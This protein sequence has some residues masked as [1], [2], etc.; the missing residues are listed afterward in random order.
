MAQTKFDKQVEENAESLMFG[1]GRVLAGRDLDGVKRTDATFWRP[2]TRVLPKVEGRVPRRSYRAGWQRLSFR[3]VL[4]AGVV[5]S[6]YLLSRDPEATARTFQDLW[7]NRDVTLA[8]LETGGIG[9][10]SAMAV[11]GVAYGLLTRERRELMR[12]WV[13]PLH[14]ALTIPLGIAEQTAP[15]RYLH[16][17]KNFTDD[18]AQIRVD[19]PTHLRFSRDVVADLITQKLAL[20]GVTFSWHPAGRKPYVLVKKTRKPPVKAA[21]KDP[22]VRELVARAKE[23]APVIGIGSS[24]RIVSVDLD[25]DSPHILVNAST[26]GGKSVT[27]RCIACQMLHHGSLVF[28]LDFKR[29]SHP[30]ARGIPGVT[31][32]ADIA[33]IHDQLIELGM[34][35]RRRTRVADELGIDADPHAI[36]PRLLI[37]LEE[38]NATMKQLARYWERIRES[39]DPKVSPAVDALNEVL[40]MGRQLRMHV[41]L[42]AQSATARALGG[43]EVREQFA[44]RILARYSVN[45]WRMLAP[46]VHPAPKS[47]KHHGRAQVVIGGTARETQVLFFTEAEAREWATTGKAA[48]DPKRAAL[49]TQLQ[50]PPAP[51]AQPATSAD[52]LTD[53]WSTAPAAPEPT[54]AADRDFLADAWSIEPQAP[55]TD[56][57]GGAADT[58]TA[59]SPANSAVVDDDQ[60]VGLRQ[61]HEHHLPEITLAALRFARANDP[62]FPDPAGKRGAELL[63]RVGDLKRWAR[64]RP[65]AASG[66]TDLG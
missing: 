5:E 43:P 27:L 34:E 33:D 56:P 29:I 53:A 16:I 17:P 28:V 10:A 44:T 45:A 20:E 55:A 40:Y 8:T 21:F 31:Y 18:D 15:R 62:S 23:S 35:G 9:A 7:G 11:G 66:T 51:D 54:Q 1:I 13:V 30:W 50:K 48:P 37:L 63:Y 38:I 2:A 26:G 65:R 24:N 46:E 52:L 64:N 58:T 60:A 36:G 6:G 22:M 61:A 47:T 57:G 59:M 3:L 14:E 25:A 19:L 41:L 32:C 4:G 12:E 42:V 39:G 49:P